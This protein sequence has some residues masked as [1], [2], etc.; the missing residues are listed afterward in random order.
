MRSA[1]RR[2]PTPNP[3]R[4]PRPR[5]P[6][7][8]PSARPFSAPARSRSSAVEAAF[9][10]LTSSGGENV[11]EKL[12]TGRTRT[13]AVERTNDG[14]ERAHHPRRRVARRRFGRHRF[15]RRQRQSSG[16]GGEPPKGRRSD[17]GARLS[18]ESFG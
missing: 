5:P 11:I 9:G 16:R 10:G 1:G 7:G 14:R 4:P 18:A 8:A 12:A 6:A 2:P 13:P 17:R 15:Q 3:P